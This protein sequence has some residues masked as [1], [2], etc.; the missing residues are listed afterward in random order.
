MA[1]A[2]KAS[3][4]H[5]L[6]GSNPA[7]SAAVTRG[8][9][10]RSNLEIRPVGVWSQ[11]GQVGLIRCPNE[12]AYSCSISRGRKRAIA[13]S[14]RRSLPTLALCAQVV[15]RSACRSTQAE[16]AAWIRRAMERFRPVVKVARSGHRSRSATAVMLS[17]LV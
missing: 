4:V 8:N 7:S 6:A 14:R 11:L 15:G 3:W 2:W 13:A 9:T 16:V 17:W 10:A 12:A 1:L 5:A